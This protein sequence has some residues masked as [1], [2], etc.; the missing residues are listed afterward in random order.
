LAEKLNSVVIDFKKVQNKRNGYNSFVLIRFLKPCSRKQPLHLKAL[1][2][3]KSD[4]N[5]SSFILDKLPFLR[6]DVHL[7]V[8]QELS[9]EISFS[10]FFFYFS[11]FIS[12]MKIEIYF[13]EL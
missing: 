6:K 4:W 3:V 13:I 11:I 7:Q 9:E 5:F 8:V 2:I 10:Y 12:V 1:F